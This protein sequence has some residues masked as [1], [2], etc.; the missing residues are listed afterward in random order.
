VWVASVGGGGRGV[1]E[2]RERALKLASP[3]TVERATLIMHRASREDLGEALAFARAKGE[4]ALEAAAAAQLAYHEMLAWEPVEC[5]RALEQAERLALGVGG[6]ADRVSCA[7][8]RWCLA[9]LTGDR[10]GADAAIRQLL[11]LAARARSRRVQAMAMR[12]SGEI[13]CH[14]GEWE[15]ARREI[16]ACLALSPHLPVFNR[17]RSLSVLTRVELNTGHLKA[18]R[19]AQETLARLLGSSEPADLRSGLLGAMVTG[20]VSRVPAPPDRIEAPRSDGPLLVWATIPLLNA[21]QGA[22]LHGD[23]RAAAPCLR[24]LRRW[25]GTFGERATD[26]LI[27]LLCDVLG[28]RD[29]A[30]A[31][32]ER[33][34]GFA[35]RAGYRPELAWCQADLADVLARRGAPGDEELGVEAARRGLTLSRQLGMA[36]LSK[37]ILARL[38]AL[39]KRTPGRRAEVDSLTNRELEVLRLVAGGLSNPEISDRLGMSPLTAARHVHNLLDKT[40]TSNRAEL[41]AWAGRKRLID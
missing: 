10:Q 38:A 28:R 27:G 16:G 6:L 9:R 34:V 13:A 17:T 1:A 31:Y 3:G 26:A 35:E 22:I 4:Q 23:K 8:T 15:R 12:C 20:D 5:L 18:A 2:L 14:R 32:I 25:T 36:P 40:G 39:E 24:H 21:A 7:Y 29:E 41:T 11:E 19:Q 37:R 33:A 30:V